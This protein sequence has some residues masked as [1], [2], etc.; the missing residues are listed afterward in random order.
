MHRNALVRAL[1]GGSGGK[2]AASVPLRLKVV[3]T[4]SAQAS[5]RRVKAGGAIQVS[6]AVSTYRPKVVLALA[7]QRPDG[8]FAPVGAVR[9]R[10]RGGRGRATVRLPRAGLYRIAA[11]APADRHAEAASAP[12]IF[13]RATHR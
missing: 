7:R 5:R 10:V 9:T 6:V 1:F 2:P 12:W 4:L 13:V 8:R 11:Q 3:P